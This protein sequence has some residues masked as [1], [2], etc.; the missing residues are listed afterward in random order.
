MFVLGVGCRVRVPHVPVLHVGFFA[1]PE[2]IHLF[3][4]NRC[5]LLL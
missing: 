2:F 3:F 4:I 1:S 5:M